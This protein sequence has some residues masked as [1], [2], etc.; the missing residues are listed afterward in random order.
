MSDMYKLQYDGMTLA[1]PGWNGYVCYEKP[2]GYPIT[3][4]S[5]EH[6]SVTGDSIYIPGS[7]GITLQSSYDTYYRISGYDIT[8]GSI[9]D[10]KLVPTG[11]CTIKAVQKV[12]AFTATGGWEK[13]SNVR[14]TV[15]STNSNT[16]TNIA[17][18]YAIHGS[19]TG[20]IPTAWYNT[21]NRWKPNDVSSYSITLNPKMNITTRYPSN[22]YQNKSYYTQITAVSLVGSTQSNSQTWVAYIK[23]NKN[24][25]VNHNYNKTFTS[26]TQ[27]VNYGLSA[28]ILI[29]NNASYNVTATYVADQTTG[30]WTATGIAP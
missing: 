13:G 4:L 9:V 17:A 20:D 28:K 18:K 27:N 3:Y 16:T 29:H 12:N 6:V 21:S 26:T 25:T 2:V 22:N 24:T 15:G 30:T 5:D 14:A 19:H 11:P 10:G 8:N 23:D 1:Y 7:E